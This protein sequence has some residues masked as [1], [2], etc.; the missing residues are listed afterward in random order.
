MFGTCIVMLPS[1]NASKSSASRGLRG[2][3]VSLCLARL[4]HS[5]FRPSPGMWRRA[6]SYI[7]KCIIKFSIVLYI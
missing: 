2:L 6:M 5:F 4:S 1:L 7:D 3:S